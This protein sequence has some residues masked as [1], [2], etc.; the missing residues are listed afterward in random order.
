MAGG[1]VAPPHVSRET[2][3]VPYEVFVFF[4]RGGWFYKLCVFCVKKGR[5][6]DKLTLPNYL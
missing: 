2:P 5:A 4:C 6:H 1:A 3:I